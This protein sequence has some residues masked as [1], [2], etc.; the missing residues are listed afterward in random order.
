MK[1]KRYIIEFYTTTIDDALSEKRY[2]CTKEYERL[3]ELFSNVGRMIQLIESYN[4]SN[5]EA[6]EDFEYFFW[7][8][9]QNNYSNEKESV[10]KFIFEMENNTLYLL[11]VHGLLEDKVE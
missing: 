6:G 5:D 10:L 1:K 8:D 11:N 4:S 9:Y 2:V 7:I 3:R